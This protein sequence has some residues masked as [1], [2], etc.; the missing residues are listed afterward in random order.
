MFFIKVD[1][2]WI[3]LAAIRTL[4][5]TSPTAFNN[6]LTV[7]IR[8]N[9]NYDDDDESAYEHL[10]N[11]EAQKFIAEWEKAR[12]INANFFLPQTPLDEPNKSPSVQQRLGAILANAICRP[13]I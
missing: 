6:T 8:W 3:N 12:K 10:E 11:D 13:R 2:C 1:N 9:N 4:T 5:V 7:T